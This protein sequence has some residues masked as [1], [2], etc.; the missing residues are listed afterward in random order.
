MKQHLTQLKEGEVKGCRKKRR[1]EY[2]EDLESISIH[3][4]NLVE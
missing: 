3:L 2:A 1:D 4:P